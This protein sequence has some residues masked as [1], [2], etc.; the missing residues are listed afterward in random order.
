MSPSE[1]TTQERI[2]KAGKE[3]F[4]NNGFKNASL[5][6]I[7]K[8]AGVTTGAIYGYYANK[9]SLFET[10]VA[11]PA[12]ILLKKFIA[13][14]DELKECPPDQQVQAM[15]EKT[16]NMLD[17]MINHIYD[18]FDAFKLIICSGA[19][20]SY[21]NYIDQLVEVEIAATRQFIEMIKL[22]GFTPQPIE[23]ELMH[24]LSNALFSGVFEVVR[25]DMSRKKAHSY[26]ERLAEF[27][28]A[29]W[30]KLLRI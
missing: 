23:D 6:S 1:K 22:A 10:L 7:A 11:E 19:G 9:H 20:T 13:V 26:A 30:D 8:R 16:S 17:W 12:T 18:H 24:I 3:E 29:G 4:L 15:H 5:R 28:R 14:L 21:E 27:T 2:L 25:H